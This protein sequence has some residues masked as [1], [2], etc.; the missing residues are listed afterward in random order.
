[1]G[2][3][4]VAAGEETRYLRDTDDDGSIWPEQRWDTFEIDGPGGERI[5]EVRVHHVLGRDSSPEAIEVSE[6]Q[7]KRLDLTRKTDPYKLGTLSSLGR[8]LETR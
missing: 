4:R 6:S 1:V 3:L 5:E 7:T 2:N 8:R